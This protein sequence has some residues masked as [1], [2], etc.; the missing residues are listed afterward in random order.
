MSRMRGVTLIELVVA[1][2]ILGLLATLSVSQLQPLGVRPR[3]TE[4]Q[5]AADTARAL[6]LRALTSGTVQRASII[7]AGR[8]WLV[9]AWPDGHVITDA[10]AALYRT[11]GEFAHVIR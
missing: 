3:V 10:P 8:A 4:Q 9:S 6:R 2:T 1:I 7:I 5:T 11:S